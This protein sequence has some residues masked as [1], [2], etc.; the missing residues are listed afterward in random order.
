MV[1]LVVV[2]VSLANLA[3]ALG[4]GSDDDFYASTAASGSASSSYV[5]G[6]YYNTCVLGDDDCNILAG[7]LVGWARIVI[8]IVGAVFVCSIVGCCYCCQCCF[9][10]SVSFFFLSLPY[11]FFPLL[12]PPPRE[13]PGTVKSSFNP[14]SVSPHRRSRGVHGPL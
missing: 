6:N 2:F 11:L 9:W 1:S 8:G 13:S 12:P 5:F 7:A 10:V 3:V 14:P 4:L